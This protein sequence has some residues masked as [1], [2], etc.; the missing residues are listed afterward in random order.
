MKSKRLIT[1][2]AVFVMS[3]LACALTFGV[4]VSAEETTSDLSAYFTLTDA[5]V[6]YTEGKIVFNVTGDTAKIESKYDFDL[7]NLVCNVETAGCTYTCNAGD[8]EAGKLVIE[9]EKTEGAETSTLTLNSLKVKGVDLYTDVEGVFTVNEDAITAGNLAL[10]EVSALVWGYEYNDVTFD[11]Y[12]GFIKDVEKKSKEIVVVYGEN[13][14]DCETKFINFIASLN[15]DEQAEVPA[16]VTVKTFTD[17][18]TIKFTSFKG[19]TY[20]KDGNEYSNVA[21]FWGQ[22]GATS[23]D[24]FS[25]LDLNVQKELQD[26]N[27]PAYDVNFAKNF[28]D[29]EAYADYLEAVEKAAYRNYDAGEY[30]YVSASYKV[31]TEIYEYIKS[32][33]FV[34]EDLTPV[35]YYKVPESDSFSKLS[36]TSTTKK[37]TLS[38]IGYYEFYVVATDPMNNEFV[39]DEEWELTTKVLVKDGSAN[40]SYIEKT[41]SVPAGSEK[42]AEVKGFYNESELKVP[43]FT[44]YLGNSNPDVT[45]NGA[46]S[47][48]AGYVGANYSKISTF[49]VEGND[50]TTTYTLWYNEGEV[51]TFEGS[52]SWKEIGTLEAFKATFN[53]KFNEDDMASEFATLAWDESELTFTPVYTG[54]YAVKCNVVDAMA[55]T[56]EAHSA[57]V[58]VNGSMNTVELHTTYMWFQNNWQSVLF[59]SIAVLSLIGIIVLLLVKPKEEKE[60]ENIESK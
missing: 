32:D 17:D 10:A 45:Y 23:G 12:H 6:E 42:V 38:K 50:V 5:T 54:S 39:V 59:L 31:P 15:A 40:Y 33:Y 9:V 18:T 3:L 14:T 7:T 53:G 22:E 51:E 2:I 47:V 55:Q 26:E 35:V 57:V 34:S 21:I 60:V 8:A 11:L 58:K 27:A 52:S 56:V 24:Y 1:L 41:A 16:Y 43:V 13:A 30:Y 25:K 49:T 44:F 46:S 19:N 37:F 4:T 29:T 36:S 48:T 28:I 20:V